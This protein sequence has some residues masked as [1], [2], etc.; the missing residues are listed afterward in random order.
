MLLGDFF[1]PACIMAA[2]MQYNSD[3]DFNQEP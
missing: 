2:S 3:L 1:P